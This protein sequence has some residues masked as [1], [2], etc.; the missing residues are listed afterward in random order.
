MSE[1]KVMLH[2]VGQEYSESGIWLIRTNPELKELYEVSENM[3]ADR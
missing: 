2:Y 1:D 3:P